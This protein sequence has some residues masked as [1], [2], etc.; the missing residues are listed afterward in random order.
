MAKMK[1][2][3]KAITED[4][5]PRHVPKPPYVEPSEEC[6]KAWMEARTML[7]LN[8]PAFS[9]ILYTMMNPHKREDTAYW[10]HITPPGA[11]HPALGAT[12]GNTLFLNPD[13]FAALSLPERVFLVAHEIS[14]AMFN[15]CGMG[16]GWQLRGYISYADGTVLDY[17]PRLMNMAMDY[18]INDML[19][20]AGVGQFIKSGCHDKTIATGNDSIAEAYRKLFE[21]M[22]Q[23]Y[24]KDFHK[25]GIEITL[26]GE[27]FDEH[28]MPGTGSGEDP[29]AADQQRNETEW[30]TQIA[31]AIASAKAQGKLPAN[32]DRIFGELIEPKVDWRE[33]IEA[34]FARKVGSGG[35][36]W[37]RADRRLIVRGMSNALEGDSIY[38]PG[39]SGFGAGTIVFV[40]DTSGSIDYRPGKVGDQFLAEL[41]GILELVR[42]K[43]IV[44]IWC[45]MAINRVDEV[46]E[47]S[48]IDAIRFKGVPGGGGTSFVPPFEE[49]E[50]MGLEP[51]ALIYLTD[52]YGT[53][54][55]AEP[56][57]P[58]CWGSI[59]DVVYPFGE[60]VRIDVTA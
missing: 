34:F 20:E 39:R 38:A 59:T 29:V 2:D 37:R 33:H 47:A 7:L 11:P 6:K 30:R 10:A 9:H 60:T 40:G 57:Y 49:V 46:E 42:P 52:G 14:H 15:H 4:R 22:E 45:D 58:V 21:K 27:G 23:Q 25:Q 26:A 13:T 17:I 8:C 56:A 50:K 16:M 1:F 32:M 3:W 51:D 54:P 12:D 24:G 19:I 53:F 36:D 31:A 18:V 55:S 43:R 48:D 44:V 28:L 41:A 5:V 35:F